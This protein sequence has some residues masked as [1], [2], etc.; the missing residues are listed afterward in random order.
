MRTWM[1]Y[2]V[3]MVLAILSPGMIRADEPTPFADV[4]CF[5]PIE[6]T[7]AT[8]HDGE[9]KRNPVLLMWLTPTRLVYREYDPNRRGKITTSW[10]DI[11]ADDPTSKIESIQIRQGDRVTTWQHVATEER[12]PKRFVGAFVPPP[13]IDLASAPAANRPTEDQLIGFAF[14]EFILSLRQSQRFVEKLPVN[15]VM[16]PPRMPMLKQ[17]AKRWLSLLSRRTVDAERVNGFSSIVELAEEFEGY[18]RRW[19]ATLAEVNA[20]LATAH[21]TMQAELRTID[22]KTGIYLANDVRLKLQRDDD[23]VDVEKYIQLAEENLAVRKKAMAV[24]RELEDKLAAAAEGTKSDLLR[25]LKRVQGKLAQHCQA[26][27]QMNAYEFDEVIDRTARLMKSSDRPMPDWNGLEKE[28]ASRL[29]HPDGQKNPYLRVKL[30][31]ARCQVLGQEA[32]TTNSAF[33][34]LKLADDIVADLRLLP[35]AEAYNQERILL[36][37]VA[38]QV[39]HEAAKLDFQGKIWSRYPH[40]AA[41]YATRLIAECEALRASGETQGKLTAL[42]AWCLFQASSSSAAVAEAN[43]VATRLESAPGF[44]INMARLCSQVPA[45]KKDTLKWLTIAMGVT[46]EVTEREAR[47][48]PHFDEFRRVWKKDFER[49]LKGSLMWEFVDGER[50]P[51]NLRVSPPMQVRLTNVSKLPLVG[52]RVGLFKP[53]QGRNPPQVLAVRSFAKIEPGESV[54]WVPPLGRA[55][56]VS[57]AN[58]AG[59]F[60]RSSFGHEAPARQQDD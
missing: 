28:Y 1:R 14:E 2:A 21:T 46:G 37:S 33:A 13:T 58:N 43:R 22:T 23:S 16:F 9:I 57:Q 50:G 8:N 45:I 4:L 36:L 12:K 7:I 51:F 18:E 31:L 3:P 44:A 27:L 40:P 41:A 29:K 10:R 26:A 54:I 19:V 35:D 38:A 48:D 39:A 49:A 20:D 47:A 5:G 11:R 52:V 42:K 24:R 34:M 6:A 59:L 53:G 60:V 55:V 32:D 15:Q 25:G 30:A 17:D 56:T